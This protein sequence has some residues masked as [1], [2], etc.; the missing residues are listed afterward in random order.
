MPDQQKMSL[1]ARIL[2]GG[3]PQGP[4]MVPNAP[5][6]DNYGPGMGP[7]MPMEG[8]PNA[9]EFTPPNAYAGDVM[10]GHAPS[11]M[12]RA[13]NYGGQAMDAAGNVIGPA[14]GTGMEA[15][16]QGGDM[17]RRKLAAI[18]AGMR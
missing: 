16:V 8:M 5:M 14:M 10:E 6:P 9:P 1:L 2:G 11:M 15:V 3:I 13:A 18:L 12:D 17:A 4:G 7:Q